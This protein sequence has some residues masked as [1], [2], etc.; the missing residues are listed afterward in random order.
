MKCLLAAIAACV[1]HVAF[2]GPNGGEVS[3]KQS[4]VP[5]LKTKCASCHLTGQE[6]GALAL[7]PGAA[8]ASL[9]N[10]KSSEAGLLRVKPGAPDQSYLLMKLLGTHLDHGGQ[11]ARM[12]FGSPPLD[13]ETIA[14][15]R[16]WIASGAPDN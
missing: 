5:V 2:A 8:Y 4:I 1:A 13:A 15:V 6:G 12:P 10:V 9:V 11:G 3:F 16:Q 14:K 7:H